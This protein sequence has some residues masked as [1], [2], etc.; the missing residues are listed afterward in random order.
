MVRNKVTLTDYGKAVA[1][2]LNNRRKELE[3]A[4][5]EYNKEHES[6]ISFRDLEPAWYEPYLTPIDGSG[7]ANYIKDKLKEIREQGEGNE[8]VVTVAEDAD[9]DFEEDIFSSE[10]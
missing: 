1:E 8:K 2:C 10:E 6:E 3:A 9:S 7:D 5:E 4:A